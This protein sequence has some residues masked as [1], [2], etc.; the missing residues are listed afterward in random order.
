MKSGIRPVL[1][2]ASVLLASCKGSDASALMMQLMA[3]PPQ[4]SVSSGDWTSVQIADGARVFVEGR[5]NGEASH[6]MIDS[7]AAMTTVDRAFAERIG[8][9]PGMSIPVSG[10]GGQGQANL[11]GGVTLEVGGLKLERMTVLITDL[12]AINARIGRP[13]EV[14]LGREAF[15]RA[16]VDL[17]TP[18]SRVAFRQREG[19]QPPE[20]AT[21]I[22]LV[23]SGGGQRSIAISIEGRPEI[24]AHFDFGNGAALFL[25]PA[26]WRENAMLEGRRSSMT[27]SGGVGGINQV[28]I[29]T[30]NT[31][32]VGG[33]TLREVPATFYS[34]A[35]EDGTAANIGF[36]IL[37][38]FRLITDYAG[39]ALYLFPDAAAAAAPFR[40]DRSGVLVAPAGE[41][42][43]VLMI[44]PGSP[45]ATGGVWAVGDEI[46]AVD[47]A[48]LAPNAAASPNYRW[49][50]RPAGT[51]VT[52]TLADGSTRQVVLADYF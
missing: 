50:A 9:K 7:G 22:P 52:L 48:P 35:A 41:R 25:R 14:I 51:T 23:R 19:F 15:E 33:I 2:A 10:S 29:A 45:A 13:I 34:V 28:P 27:M 4:V 5:F 24:E 38:R 42:Q 12:S 20:G 8:L 49:G 36:G 26:Y 46:V 1:L 44:A 3:P 6:L 40:K 21:R 39:D 43:R 18:N 11:A 32:T 30:L 16:I 47:G 17:D 31:V 37:G